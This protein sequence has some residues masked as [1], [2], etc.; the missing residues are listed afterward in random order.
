MGYNLKGECRNTGRT[1]FKKGYSP[2]NKGKTGVYSE[3]QKKKI[4]DF[5]RKRLLEN[6]PFKGKHHSQET[7]EKIT[8]SLLKFYEENP[9]RTISTKGKPWS[10]NRRLSQAKVKRVKKIRTNP[11]IKNG[12]EYHPMWHELRRSIYKRDGWKCQE[13]GVHCHNENKIQC[14]LIDYDTTNN[15]ISNLI[16]L[17]SVCH[18]KSNYKRLDWMNHYKNKMEEVKSITSLL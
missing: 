17:C 18:G 11:V 7:K 8:R 10:K 15:D 13:C 16:T 12:K 4:G 1:H 3:E 2:W 5:T 6:H 9:N 14:H